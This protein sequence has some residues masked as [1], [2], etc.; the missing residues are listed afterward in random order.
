M[1]RDFGREPSFVEEN[2]ERRSTLRG[3]QRD[4][5]AELPGGVRAAVLEAGKKGVFVA[6]DDPDGF[7]LGARLE[8]AIAGAI[9][10]VTARVDVIRKE[11][12]PRRGIALLIVHMAPAAEATYASLTGEPSE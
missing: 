7:A 2:I 10:K 5:W 11:I 4:L 1:P 8:V 9:G 3:P 6:V 12:H